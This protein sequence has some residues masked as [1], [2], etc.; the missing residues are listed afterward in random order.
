MNNGVMANGDIV[1]DDCFCFLIGAMDNTAILYINF[2]S[3]TDTVYIPPHNSIEPDAAIIPEHHIPDDRCIGCDKNISAKTRRN[4]FDG[5]NNGHSINLVVMLS[6]G[7]SLKLKAESL[8][9]NSLI[10]KLFNYRV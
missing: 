8:K 5:K 1:P 3:D 10:F 2:I 4:A 7:E 9:L 6:Y